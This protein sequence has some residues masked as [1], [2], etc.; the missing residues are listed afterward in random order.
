MEPILVQDI[1]LSTNFGFLDWLSPEMGPLPDTAQLWDF[2][3]YRFKVALWDRGNVCVA[4]ELLAGETLPEHVLREVK[5]WVLQTFLWKRTK[6]CFV[7]GNMSVKP[8]KE[9]KQTYKRIIELTLR[10]MVNAQDGK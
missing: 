7:C 1:N 2:G 10:R 8:N 4:A 5:G 6:E 9:V 3:P